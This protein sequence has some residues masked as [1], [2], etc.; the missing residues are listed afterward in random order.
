M[1]VVLEEIIAGSDHH[2]VRREER[3]KA[4]LLLPRLLLHRRCRG[5][6]IGKE[7]LTERFQN[8]WAGRWDGLLAASIAHDEEGVH[9][10]QQKASNAEPRAIW[11]IGSTGQ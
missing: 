6:K 11:S 10:G 5:G 3:W 4:F 8:F 1:K 2:D 7:K 9:N